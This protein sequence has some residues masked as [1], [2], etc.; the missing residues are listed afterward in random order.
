MAHNKTLALSFIQELRD[1]FPN[2]VSTLSPM[3]TTNQKPI[4]PAA[5][6]I[7][8]KKPPSTKKSTNYAWRPPLT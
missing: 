3:I 5:T 6:L 7:L 8:K 4:C 2:A 1:F